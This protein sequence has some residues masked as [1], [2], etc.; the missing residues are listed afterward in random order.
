MTIDKFDPNA[1][2]VNNNKLK[3]YRFVDDQKL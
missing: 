1:I 2:L 3:P